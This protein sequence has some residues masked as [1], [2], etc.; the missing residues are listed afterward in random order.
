MSTPSTAEPTPAHAWEH[1]VRG[2]QIRLLYE[3][4]AL[5]AVVTMAVSSVLGFLQWPVIPHGTVVAWVSYMFVVSIGRFDLWQMY[6]RR[7]PSQTVST[8]G[9]QFSIG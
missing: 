4:T 1:A 2:E 9:L 7:V 6:R 3:N 8:W 5:S